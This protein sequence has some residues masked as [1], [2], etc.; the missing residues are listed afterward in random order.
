[1]PTMLSRSGQAGAASARRARFRDRALPA[2][3]I[4]ALVASLFV[5]VPAQRVA[6]AQTDPPTPAVAIHVSE[7][8]AALETMTASAPTPTGTGTT[9][10]QWWITWWRYFVAYQSLEEALKADGT[11]YVEVSD[12]DIAAGRLVTADGLARYPIVF[13]LAAEAVAD[14]E[15]APLRNYVSAGGFLFVGSSSFTRSTNGTARG[16]FA[17][18]SEMG[19]RMSSTSLQN[20]TLNDQ[21]AKAG[22]S[23]LTADIPSGTLL[24]GGKQSYDTTPWINN[25]RWVWRVTNTDAQVLA[26]GDGGVELATKPYGTG[27]FIYDAELQPLLGDTGYSSSAFAYTIYRNAVEWAFEASGMPIVK[28]SP[29]RYPYDAAGIVRHDLEAMTSPGSYILNSAQYEQSLGMKGDYYF[30]TGTLRISPT[31]PD[32]RMSDTAKR[33]DIDNLRTAVATYGATVGSHNGGL[34]NPAGYPT[35]ITDSAAHTLWHWG[36]DQALDLSPA[37][38]PSGY[39]YAQQSLQIAFQDIETW[40]SSSPYTGATGRTPVDNGRAGCGAAGT[41][42]RT[43][44]SPYHNAGRERSHQIE[45]DLGTQVVGEQRVG[46]FPIRDFSYAAPHT[47]FSMVGMGIGNWYIGDAL[48]ESIDNYLGTADMRAAVDWYYDLG[49]LINLYGHSDLRSYVSYLAS[50]AN[51]WKT[52]AVGVRD[53]YVKREPVRVTPSFTQSGSAS[54]ATATVSGS[55]DAQTAVELVIPSWTPVSTSVSVRL[56]GAAAPAGSWRS[57]AYGVKIQVGTTVSSIEVTYNPIQPVQSWTQTDWSGGAGQDIWADPTR[58]QA[59]TN[60]DTSA[61]GQVSLSATSGGGAVFSDTFT[62]QPNDPAPLSPWTSVSGTWTVASGVLTGTGTSG[63]GNVYYVPPTSPPSDYVVDARV[64]LTPGSLGGGIGGRLNKTTGAH[65]GIWLYPPD[66]PAA[67]KNNIAVIK[68]SSWTAYTTPAI[69]TYSLDANWHDLRVEFAG[70]RIRVW[71]D[72]AQLLDYTDPSPLSGSGITVDRYPP[73]TI[74]VDSVTMT[75]PVT[76]NASGSL[77]SSAF[78][79]GAGSTWQT[80]SWQASTLT[81]TTVRLRT[82]TADTSAGLASAAWSAWYPASGAPIP[83]ASRRWMQYQAE[84][85]TSN[86]AITPS[87]YDVTATYA[88]PAPVDTIPPVVTVPANMTVP[89]TGPSGAVVTFSASA[90]DNVDGALTPTC[91]PASGSTFPVGSTTVTCRATDAA[92]NTGSASFSVT[93]TAVVDEPPAAP[94]GLTAAVSTIAIALDWGD[95]SEPDLAGY[96]VYRSLAS[97]GPW[98][99]LTSAPITTSDYGDTS[100]PTGT[101]M[102]YRVTAVDLAGLESGA[103]STSAKRTIAFRS[104]TFAANSGAT[105]LVIA[106]P[107]GAQTNDI[108]VAVVTVRGAPTITPPSGWTLIR[109]D[110]SGTTLKQA[111]YFRA[112]DAATDTSFTWTFSATSLVSGAIVA[113]SGVDVL[114]VPVR[115]VDAAD[116]RAT[117]SSTS[118]IVAPS[119]TTSVEGDLLIGAFGSATNATFDPPSSM[120]E[121]GEIVSTAGK[122]RVATEIADQVLGPAGPTGDRA[123]TASKSAVVVGQLI[124]LR[125]VG[126]TP[127]PVDTE[128]PTP[129]T[130]LAVTATSSTRVDLAW[131]AATDN[132]GVDRYVVQRATGTGAFASI[133]IATV[134]QFADSTV[135]KNTTYRYRV[136]AVDAASNTSDPSGIVSVTTPRR[137]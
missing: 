25:P 8:T 64:Q 17:L 3:G 87:L 55:T 62:R 126:S 47:Y 5:G 21:F 9:G 23:R 48:Q 100:A 136:M 110:M 56:N 15:I 13:S 65:Y 33:A 122:S 32:T 129:P 51:L 101:E 81:G 58:Y 116:G 54:I 102:Y 112:V 28:V 61:T 118:S 90:V 24:W 86:P 11:P 72:G 98:T 50:K 89:A 132:V 36:P 106:R 130:N 104:S 31:N 43:F 107:T 120:I 60:V 38:Y 128:K 37:G 6:A 137:G 52:N 46:P 75:T 29:W 49:G 119:I 2:I 125:P 40:M 68:F 16:G 82:R 93:V 105:T 99:Q 66:G 71:M 74:S 88:G 111:T 27:R 135:S 39:A 121:Q 109:S 115:P 77:V 35:P 76:F 42:P 83:D 30:T 134:P 92:G 124:A 131:T 85:G 63:Y 10:M 12:A 96:R 53:W 113:Y 69:A 97:G 127:P 4:L 22:S 79:A 44:V 78:D 45:N 26:T 18:Q 20:W 108:L 14:N 41:C 7:N 94:T 95:N 123:A 117:T 133:G 103:A 80:L 19:L 34:P 1:M 84:L 70:A 59:G 67:N 73:T 91:T 114:N 57:T